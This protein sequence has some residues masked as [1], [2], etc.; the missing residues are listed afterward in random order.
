MEQEKKVILTVDTGESQKTVKSLK[1][2]I[3]DLKDAILNLEKGS[4]EY[5]DAVEQ[6]TVSQREL[7]E[8]QALTKKTAVALDGSYD[9]LVHQMGL[10]KKEWRATADEGRRAELGKEISKINQQLK[11][12]DA[13][14]GNYQRNVGNY[15]SHWDGMPESLNEAGRGIKELRAEIKQYQAQVLSAEEGTKEWE[16]AMMKLSQ[17]QFEMRDMNEKSRYAVADLGEQLSNISG[18]ASGLVSGFSAVQGAMVLCGVE[19]KDF[20]KTM[21]K[22]QSAMAIVQGLQ[23]LEGLQDRVTGLM[24]SIKLA[25]KAMGKGGWIGIIIAV[26]AAISALTVHLVKKNKEIKNGTAALREYNKA[27]NENVGAAAEQIVK[28]QLLDKISRDAA[29]ADEIRNKAAKELLKTI[30][31]SITD[32]NILA[33]KNGEYADTIKNK[34]IPALIAQARMEG[35][36]D[37]IKAKQK[38]I[39]EQQVKVNERIA[40]APTGWDK[41]QAGL[42][43]GAMAAETNAPVVEVNAEDFKE[44]GVERQKKKLQQMEADFTVFVD[45]LFKDFSSKEILVGL[46][47]EVE[48]DTDKPEK[49]IKEKAMS[50]QEALELAQKQIMESI[51]EDILSIDAEIDIEV[52]DDYIKD[53]DEKNERLKKSA[54]YQ[55]KLA[56]DTARRE[57]EY[58]N[59]KAQK[60]KDKLAE[61]IKDKD[62]LAEELQRI[63][64]ERAV[65]EANINLKTA[66]KKKE[67]LD[68]WVKNNTDA[69]ILLLEIQES[70]AN[71][72]IEIAKAKYAQLKAMREKAANDEDTSNTERISRFSSAVKDFNEQWEDMEWQG[73]LQ[74]ISDVTSQMLY[75]T[76]DILNSIADMYE[77]NDEEAEKNAKKIKNLRIAGATIDMLNGAVMAFAQAQS[78]YPPLG[79]IVGAIN[80]ATVL[81]MGAMNIAKIKNTDATGK[82]APSGGSG[83]ASVTPNLASYASEIPASFTRNITTSSEIDEMNKEQRV[84]LVESDMVDALKKVEIRSS[85]SSF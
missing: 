79:P 5:N 70:I 72:E 17:A 3:A 74:L 58:L 53:I 57:I 65:E 61:E 78:L 34:V 50:V 33:V 77:S 64:D 82:S 63:E 14:L 85:E 68:E 16:E 15:V 31:D 48:T 75:N 19:T 6:L 54:E 28:I 26:V 40:E 59:L 49:D 38:E 42:V 44:E 81:A 35:A 83:S 1:K 66:E 8:V 62:K 25:S 71:N 76:S 37:L 69:A 80:A 9:A 39:L 12:M 47:I 20:E 52:S 84:V 7:N 11:D 41:V 2:D 56:E 67:I 22:L 18:I 55:I 73:K 51:D 23:G 24:Q 29:E 13:E 36:L 45:N 43:Q 21:L 27:A 10:L 46:G 4:D 30:G 32:T 60:D